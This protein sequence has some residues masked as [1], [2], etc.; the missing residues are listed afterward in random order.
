MSL[1]RD[2]KL[3]KNLILIV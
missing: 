1:E 2:E 3:I